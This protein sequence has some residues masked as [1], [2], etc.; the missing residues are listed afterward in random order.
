MESL[1]LNLHHTDVENAA[2]HDNSI[3]I[4][5]KDSK[6][7]QVKIQINGIE[8]TINIYL[9]RRGLVVVK[10]ASNNTNA[11][12]YFGKYLLESIKVNAFG[13]AA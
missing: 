7:I 1:S 13:V 3:I 5:H 8:E 6:H 4:L 9:F 11:I 10:S 12:S 2:I